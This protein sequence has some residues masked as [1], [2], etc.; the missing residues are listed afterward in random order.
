M[1]SGCGRAAL[2]RAS[3]LRDAKSDEKVAIV[4]PLLGSDVWTAGLNRKARPRKP[5]LR[6]LGHSAMMRHSHG[7]NKSAGQSRA[8]CWGALPSQNLTTLMVQ[9]QKARKRPRSC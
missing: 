5:V 1:R 2:C 3:T 8:F 9:S 4:L 7:A 6:Q